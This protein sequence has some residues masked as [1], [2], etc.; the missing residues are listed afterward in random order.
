MF[1]FNHIHSHT[2]QSWDQRE[3][4][5]AGRK[6]LSQIEP[7]LNSKREPCLHQISEIQAL[8]LYFYDFNGKEVTEEDKNP[9]RQLEWKRSGYSYSE[10]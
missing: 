5:Q 9:E 3:T 4:Y 6:N 2:Q 7:N 8:S 10:L 1:L